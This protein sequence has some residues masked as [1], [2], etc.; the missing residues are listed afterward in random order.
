[1][2]IFKNEENGFLGPKNTE[3]FAGNVMEGFGN[4]M[5]IAKKD[6]FSGITDPF[7]P[8][9]P[10]SGP[11]KTTSTNSVPGSDKW[12]YNPSGYSN[13]LPPNGGATQS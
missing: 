1:M 12:P 5:N 2:P 10:S 4:N 8:F 7:N 13:P 3:M 11:D 9:V 6:G